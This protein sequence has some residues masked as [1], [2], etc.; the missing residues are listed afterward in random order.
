MAAQTIVRRE[1]GAGIKRVQNDYF[2]L[3]QK[4]F[5]FDPRSGSSHLP[6]TDSNLDPYDIPML[7]VLRQM[8]ERG[9]QGLSR[10]PG[11]PH[12]LDF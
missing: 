5:K 2:E 3:F 8:T 7:S 1:I 4:V 9:H 11:E 12:W 10:G 6:L